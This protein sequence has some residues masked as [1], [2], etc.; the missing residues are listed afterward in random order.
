[1]SRALRLLVVDDEEVIRDVLQTL[2]ER[3]GYDV[4][5]AADAAE[6]LAQFDADP[7]DI[8]LLDLMLPDRPGLEV[9]RAI[10]SR[11]PDAVVVI[12]TAYSSIEGAIDAM[13]EGAFHYIPAPFRTS[14][15][16]LIVEKGAEK[17]QLTEEKPPPPPGALQALRARPHRRKVRRD[18]PRL[19]LVRLAGPSNHDPRRGR[20]ATWQGAVARAIHT[21]ARPAR[22]PFRHRQLGIH[23]DGP[24]ESNLFGHVRGAFTGAVANKKGL[25]EGPR[26]APSSS[27]RS[28][29]SAWRRRPSSCAS[30]R[31]KSSCASA[32]SRR[33]KPMCASSRPPT[34]T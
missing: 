34:W 20:A 28:G 33:R 31:K 18:A 3:Q 21:H 13:R 6:A 7:F 17:R 11:D 15:V 24:A 1:M 23:A 19:E 14:E 5:T 16:L 2:L 32:R 8:V 9:L 22:A 30:S 4:M 12:V 26:A 10:R 27:T 29:R 25:F